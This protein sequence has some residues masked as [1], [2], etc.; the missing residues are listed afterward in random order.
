MYQAH[1][2]IKRLSQLQKNSPE[3]NDLFIEKAHEFLTLDHFIVQ[4]AA[5]DLLS[6]MPPQAKSIYILADAMMISHSEQFFA[7]ALEELDRHRDK[8][9]MTK[10]ENI[11]IASLHR[12]DFYIS[13]LV[14]KKLRSK[15][16][17]HNMAGYEKLIE[18]LARES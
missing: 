17:K 10:I 16:N 14:K 1:T 15:I 7:A 18:R 3:Y 9:V 5:L 11:Y 2:N 13:A 4:I 8:E 6:Q 12:N